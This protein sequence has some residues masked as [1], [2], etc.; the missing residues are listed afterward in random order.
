MRDY[1]KEFETASNALKSL[2]NLASMRTAKGYQAQVGSPSHQANCFVEV[3]YQAYAGAA[4][5]HTT[6]SD[7]KKFVD[8][9]FKELQW[10]V[11]ERAVELATAN[12][13]EIAKA[14]RDQLQL[15]DDAIQAGMKGG[16]AQ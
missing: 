11:I 14:L 15:L 5:Y 16:Q 3:C 1:E 8:Q 2:T 10:Q 13:A 6:S 12:R 9:A 7:A 4:N